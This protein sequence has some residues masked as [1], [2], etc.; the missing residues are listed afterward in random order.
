YN[1]DVDCAAKN[2]KT[3]EVKY[4]DYDDYNDYDEE[5]KKVKQKKSKISKVTVAEAAE[6]IDVSYLEAFLGDISVGCLIWLM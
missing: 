2:G 1:E 4:D 3:E 5:V 6:Q